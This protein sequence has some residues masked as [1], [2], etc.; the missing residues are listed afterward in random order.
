MR[1]TL[2]MTIHRNIDEESYGRVHKLFSIF[3]T[4]TAMSPI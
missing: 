2:H 1:S 4:W 3:N